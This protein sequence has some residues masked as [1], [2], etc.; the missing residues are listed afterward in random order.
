MVVHPIP[1]GRVVGLL[2]THLAYGMASSHT[3]SSY[4]DKK[5]SASHTLTIF[6]AGGKDRDGVRLPLLN[7]Q[8]VPL[9]VSGTQVSIHLQGQQQF[10]TRM[11]S[12]KM[13]VSTNEKAKESRDPMVVADDEE[14]DP[15]QSARQK[16]IKL[17]LLSALVLIIAYVVIDYT[18]SALKFSV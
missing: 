15:A 7:N 3:T 8:P 2:G 9:Q 13:T 18:V 11:D 14:E 5:R 16:Y 1:R 6:L 17:G 4:S 12:T 10:A